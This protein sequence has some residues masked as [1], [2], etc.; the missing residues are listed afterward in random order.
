MYLINVICLNHVFQSCVFLPERGMCTG[1]HSAVEGYLGDFFKI[2][3]LS[4]TT[5]YTSVGN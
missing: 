1:W 5:I 4:K 2:Y 3:V